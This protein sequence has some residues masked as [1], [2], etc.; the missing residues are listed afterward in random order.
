MKKL[1]A[2][3]AMLALLVVGRV[4]VASE[5]VGWITVLDEEN[6]EIVLDSGQT[7]SL[8]DEIDFSSLADGRHV[9]VI[10]ETIGGINTATGIA[11]IPSA[12][13]Q[14]EGLSL[15]GPGPFCRD[16]STYSERKSSAK[17]PRL[18]C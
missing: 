13:D 5:A 10:Y 12:T 1:I 8:S 11:L 3:F 17:Q 2:P 6:D 15:E 16:M 7:F 18:Y 4:A 14:V 9:R